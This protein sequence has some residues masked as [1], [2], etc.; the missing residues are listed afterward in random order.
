MFAATLDGL[1][2]LTRYGGRNLRRDGSSLRAVV[3]A[4]LLDDASA[5][6]TSQASHREFDFWQLRH[7]LN[8]VGC[9][10]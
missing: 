8:V 9:P 5:H 3:G 10:A 7:C 2:H 4:Q 6:G 1:N